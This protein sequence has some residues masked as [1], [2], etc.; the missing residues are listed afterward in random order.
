MNIQVSQISE[1]EGLTIRH[2]YPEGEPA[3]VGQE[4]RLVRETALSARATREGEKVKMVGSLKATVQIEC[5]RCLTPIIVPI[6]QSFDLLYVPPLRAGSAQEE[7]EL[8]DKDLS[9]AFY[10]NQTIDC[11]DLVREQIELTL[12]MARLCSDDCRGLCSQCGANLNEGLCACGGET[13]DSRWAALKAFKK[14]D[15]QGSR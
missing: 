13:A 12:P 11:D 2:L 1:D 15:E 4:S 7:H 3:L 14:S 5:D 10:Q 6:D 9:V 8:A